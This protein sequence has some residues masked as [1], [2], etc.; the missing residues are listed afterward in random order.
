MYRF[1]KKYNNGRY[2]HYEQKPNE[3]YDY[4]VDKLGK[5]E[6]IE[7]ELGIDLY[8]LFKVLVDGAWFI[9]DKKP[10]YVRN[11]ILC[12]SENYKREIQFRVL[13]SWYSLKDYGKTWSLD[14]SDLVNDIVKEELEND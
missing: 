8:S 12:Y 11:P 14:K 5:L 1:T 3:D 9:I 2:T 13:F 4:L 7:E 6:D 10:I